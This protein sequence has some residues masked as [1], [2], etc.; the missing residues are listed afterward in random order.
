M[1]DILRLGWYFVV[2]V[3]HIVAAGLDIVA[4]VVVVG[5]LVGSWFDS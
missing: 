5:M 4:W 2:V 3:Q 1:Q